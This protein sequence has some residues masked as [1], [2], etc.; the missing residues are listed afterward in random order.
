MA[1]EQP[2]CTSLLYQVRRFLR[3]HRD[4]LADAVIDAKEIYT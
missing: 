1:R 2:S 3:R 4:E